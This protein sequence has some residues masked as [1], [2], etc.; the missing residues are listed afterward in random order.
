MRDGSRFR[1]TVPGK[2]EGA[3]YSQ[4]MSFLRARNLRKGKS[5]LD[6]L[7]LSYQA[8]GTLGRVVVA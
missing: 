2:N 3:D 1:G 7:G 8:E 6:Y 5:K 4:Q